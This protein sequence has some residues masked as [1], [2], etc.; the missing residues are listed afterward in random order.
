MR[1]RYE[2]EDSLKDER[3]F[4][5]YIATSWAM[6]LYK[7][8]VSYNLDYMGFRDDKAV[9]VLEIKNRNFELG[10]YPTLF[11]ALSKFLNAQNYMKMGLEFAVAV[12]LLNGDFFYKWDT[13]HKLDIKMGGRRQMRD[14]ADFEPL[15]HI[16]FDYFEEIG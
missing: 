7:M 4:A 9:G 1:P 8:P 10:H 15:I 11:I 16:P 2:T 13:S 14:P 5:D 12:R 6:D 3:E